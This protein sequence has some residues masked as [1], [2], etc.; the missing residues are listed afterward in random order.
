[1]AYTRRNTTDGVTVMNKDLYDNLQDGIENKPFYYDSVADMKA[2]LNLKEG[3]KAV[4]LGYYSPNDG[5]GA[6][7]IIKEKYSLPN[8]ITVLSLKDGKLC[9]EIQ[10]NEMGYYNVLTLGVERNSGKDVTDR[11]NAIL[12]IL[13]NETIYFPKGIYDVTSIKISY[14][15]T[16]L[17]SDSASYGGKYSITENDHTN[18][19]TIL[20]YCGTG[21]EDM[22]TIAQTVKV[23]FD[24]ITFYGNSV[25]YLHDETILPTVGVG[26]T[27][28]TEKISLQ[29][30]NGFEGQGITVKHCRFYKF[31]G[32]AVKVTGLSTVIECS[33]NWCATAILVEWDCVID[34]IIIGYG[35]TGILCKPDRLSSCGANII[36]NIRCDGLMGYPIELIDS[37]RN[38]IMGLVVDQIDKA[39]ICL[40]NSRNNSFINCNLN[41]T[42]KYYA[43]SLKTDLPNETLGFASA[44]YFC[45]ESC[46][47]NY[48][49]AHIYQEQFDDNTS[50]SGVISPSLFVISEAKYTKSNN[51]HITSFL[52]LVTYDKV[53][54]GIENLVS[55]F[56][57][58]Y[59]SPTDIFYINSFKVITQPDNFSGILEI[60]G[61][62]VKSLYDPKYLTPY[63]IGQGFLYN[64]KYYI[65]T[66][67]KQGSW[68]EINTTSIA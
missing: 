59:F 6:T 32:Y 15:M 17:G 13:Y 1:M 24:G 11:I 43:G 55:A 27:Q 50:H 49:E 38:T 54:N 53:I 22:V 67:V 36:S 57:G 12:N 28:N 37:V 41:R 33:F 7:Y 19:R 31:S 39:G 10:K 8:E 52:Q 29:N 62:I 58:K 5:G 63:Y 51:I 23:I 16:F 4:T 66:D 47:G 64:G 45:G 40:N 34:N 21:N 65:A 61:C 25:E 46:L 14:P 60:N 3:M 2:D 42:A 48:I 20:R 35:R 26:A 56:N 18:E 30:V 9:A 44:I 68:K